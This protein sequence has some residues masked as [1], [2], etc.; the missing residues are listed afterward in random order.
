[1]HIETP[2]VEHSS[3]SCFFLLPIIRTRRGTAPGGSSVFAPMVTRP[4]SH[5][6]YAVRRLLYALRICDGH[7]VNSRRI[8]SRTDVGG[9][10]CRPLRSGVGYVDT[11]W[12]RSWSWSWYG[13]LR[14]SRCK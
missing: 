3:N 2:G 13:T 6:Q 10:I 7:D 4:P 9:Y 14:V 8:T 12:S 1:M 5:L 11:F